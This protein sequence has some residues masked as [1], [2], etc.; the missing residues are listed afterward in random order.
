[1]ERFSYNTGEVKMMQLL[2]DYVEVTAIAPNVLLP[3]KWLTEWNSKDGA[4][5]RTQALNAIAADVSAPIV[6]SSISE[7]LFMNPRSDSKS[8][9]LGLAY[10]FSFVYSPDVIIP[11]RPPLSGLAWNLIFLNIL[12]RPLNKYMTD[13][14]VVEGDHC[15]AILTAEGG[16]LMSSLKSRSGLLSFSSISSGYSLSEIPDNLEGLPLIYDSE[17]VLLGPVVPG[18]VASD[19]LSE[20]ISSSDALCATAQMER[21]EISY[22]P[23]VTDDSADYSGDGSKDE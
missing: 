3:S 8:H 2:S 22:A 14:V 10:D 1:M 6:I 12:S 13:L 4:E 20:F 18:F 7:D 19:V 23:A 5:S 9:A 15:H 11:E 21:G 16:P 17:A